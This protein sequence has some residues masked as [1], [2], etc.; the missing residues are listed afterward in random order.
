MPFFKTGML[1]LLNL[2]VFPFLVIAIVYFLLPW[3]VGVYVLPDT[4]ALIGSELLG[5]LA[6]KSRKTIAAIMI[7]TINPSLLSSSQNLISNLDGILIPFTHNV[8]V[9]LHLKQSEAPL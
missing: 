6:K 8:E 5:K 3:D 7:T 9:N 4:T 1:L 2:T